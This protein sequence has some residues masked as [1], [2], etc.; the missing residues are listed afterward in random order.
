MVL[1]VSS[2]IKFRLKDSSYHHI[3]C[4]RRHSEILDLMRKY[5]IDYDKETME[6]GFMTSEDKFVDRRMA[7]Y[8]ARATGQVSFDFDKDYLFSEDIWPADS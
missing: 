8:V 6:Q 5:H 3:I 4:G 1:L 7:V 2:A